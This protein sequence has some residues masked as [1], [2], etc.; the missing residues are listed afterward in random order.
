MPLASALNV[1]QPID[2]A[3]RLRRHHVP[4]EDLTREA[5]GSEE[6]IAS[7]VEADAEDLQTLFLNRAQQYSK[8]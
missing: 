4:E 6:I 7:G 1:S 8:V 5:R 2:G 3:H